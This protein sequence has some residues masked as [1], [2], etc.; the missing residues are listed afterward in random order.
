MKLKKLVVQGFKSFKD[1]TNIYFDDG[2]T[3]IVGPN[4]CGKSNI[5]DALFWVM[6]EQSAKHLRGQT[7]RDVIFSGSSKYGAGGFAEATLV[8]ENIEGKHIHI[9]N[10]VS[11]PE[12]ISITRK[13][14]RNGESEYRI[15]NMHCRLKDIQEVFMDT[16]AGAKSYS[17]IAQGEINRLVQSKPQER[18]TMIEEVAGI[19]KFK[20]RRRDSLKKIDQTKENLTRLLDLQIEIE[21]NLKS[22]Q[23]QAEKASKAKSLK[24]KIHRYDL[25]VSSHKVFDHLKSFKDGKSNLVEKKT[26]LA[27]WQLE[28]DQIEVGLEEERIKRDSKSEQVDELQ[29]KFNKFSK[30]LATAEE[31]FN[32]YCENLTQ[33]ESQEGQRKAELDD[34]SEDVLLQKEKL[35]ELQASLAEITDLDDEALDF[36]L[37]EEQVD[38]L[39]EK[40]SEIST[41]KIELDE[42]YTS[43]DRNVNQREK[44]NFKNTSKIEEYKIQLEDINEEIENLEKKYSSISGQITD[45][46]NNVVEKEDKLS[47][48]ET[49]KESVAEE[50]K[51]LG[52]EERELKNTMEMGL[53]ELIKKESTH[54]S[55]VEIN[56]S[57][58]GSKA[59]ASEYLKEFGVHENTIFGGLIEC[60]EMYT[61]GVQQILARY[62][63][64]ILPGEVSWGEFL[65]WASENENGGSNIILADY[66]ANTVSEESFERLKLNF[67]SEVTPL[68]DIVKIQGEYEE[69]FKNIFSGLYLVEKITAEEIEKV[70]KVNIDFSA[71]VSF[72]GK[73]HIQNEGAFK[74]IG[75]NVKT[76]DDSGIIERNNRISQ[77]E[78]E[79]EQ[80]KVEQDDLTKKYEEKVSEYEDKKVSLEDVRE[81]LDN[82][83][84]TYLEEKATLNAQ[85]KNMEEGSSRLDILQ[86]RK[87]EISKSRFTLLENEEA[88]QKDLTA[89]NERRDELRIRLDDINEEKENI[90]DTYE[91]KRDELLEKKVFIR[92]RQD[93]IKNFEVRINETDVAISKLTDKEV[94]VKEIIQTLSDEIINLQEGIESLEK[95]N[96]DLARGLE[97]REHQLKEIKEELNILVTSMKEREDK[98]KD[99]G[100]KIMKNQKGLLEVEVKI[101]HDLAEEE[102][103]VKNTF[104]KYRIDL[105]EIIGRFLEF[106][107]EDFEA[108]IDISEIYTMETEEGIK[109]VEKVDY[110]FV[111]KYGQDLKEFP[112][113]LRQAKADLNRLGNINWQAVEDYERQKVRFDFLKTQEV[114]LTS[115]LEDLEKAIEQIDVKSK[116][117]FSEAFFEVNTRFE[118][119]FPIIFGGGNAE[120]R[121]V[122]DLNDPDCG[123]DIVASPPGKKMQNINL[124][125]G[126]EKAL[127]ALSLIF[128]IFLV[129]PSPFCLLDEVDAPLDDAN[130]GR[131]NQLLKEMSSESQFILITHNKKTMELNNVLYG[132]TM[133][134]PGVSQAVSVQLH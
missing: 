36:S 78:T 99:L 60:E 4:G 18:R 20:L 42:E 56:E 89:L 74:V 13:L 24:E 125:S 37:L 80:L 103:I 1:R 70:S 10:K 94:N 120:L 95:S 75:H 69:Q 91:V 86:K 85:L 43:L 17:I 49:L 22:L 41:N 131:F 11:S 114:E 79:I 16:G 50:I 124:M 19:T 59:S 52:S 109:D 102:Q 54:Q 34:I 68:M 38:E 117:R 7:M 112:G 123:V 106:T 113:K 25:V 84:N 33:K 132:V 90:N 126:G 81:N 2:I 67:S 96:I 128:S 108:L 53:K 111:R 105:R 72:D 9:G 116:Q 93:K 46:R 107:D 35:K 71:I 62:L 118:K 83:R 31:K 44:D 101:E 6:G 77:L 92:T 115:S 82:F 100:H 8:L 110:T 58:D 127:T 129:K 63:E 119:V 47:E 122:G 39:K 26:Q 98:V 15:N 45:A 87:K 88:F 76:G 104:D 134:E 133:Q 51:T 97:D 27:S 66:V 29:E 64:M 12:E 61:S 14:Y 121:L 28:K 40:L 57:S 65:S 23:H 32:N 21:K 55:L 3:G 5:V 30:E 130:V 48:L 73:T